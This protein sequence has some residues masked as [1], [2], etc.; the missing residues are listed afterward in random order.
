MFLKR[1]H[2][3]ILGEKASPEKGSLSRTALNDRIYSEFISRQKRVS[4]SDG[5]LFPTNFVIYLSQ[6]DYEVWNETF[7]YTVKEVV[8]RFNVA[9]RQ[10]T[11]KK[12]KNYVPHS[13]FWQFQFSAF[14]EGGLVLRDGEPETGLEDGDVLIVSKLHPDREL[15]ELWSLWWF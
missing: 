8:D 11:R 6:N 4:T 13:Q 15:N 5:L 9:I 10:M 1:L 14:P 2:R 12:Y 7:P 3:V